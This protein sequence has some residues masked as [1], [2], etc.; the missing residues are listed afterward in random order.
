MIINPY[1]LSSGGAP[2]MPTYVGKG[3]IQESTGGGTFD[4]PA[5][6][7][8]GDYL[9]LF[10]ETATEDIATPSGW[11]ELSVS[12]NQYSTT[13]R[14]MV[15]YRVYTSGDFS[16]TISDPGD[17]FIGIMV[18]FSGVGGI[19]FETSSQWAGTTAFDL[20][21]GVSTQDNVMVVAMLAGGAD[22]TDSRYQFQGANASLA[23]FTQRVSEGTIE[24]NGGSVD[25]WTGEKASTG[26]CGNI[27]DTLP[28]ASAGAG[29]VIG[30][31]GV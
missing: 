28:I 29:I 11:T 3:T 2:A 31:Y 26:D 24:G 13:T 8:S 10:I 30:L 18:A 12:P 5:G 16:V 6:I 7:S 15:F 9:F 27:T 20:D 4:T 21:C 23:N 14:L 1:I 17:H 25:M 19:D 22:N